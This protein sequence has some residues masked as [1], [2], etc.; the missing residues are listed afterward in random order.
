MPRKV[1]VAAAQMEIISGDYEGNLEKAL[2]MIKEAARN[3]ADFVCLPEF[4][5]TGVPIFKEEPIPGPTTD[6]LCEKA[7]ELNI[8][9]IGGTIRGK[10]D[11]EIYNSCCLINRKG[12]I[13]ANYSKIHLWIKE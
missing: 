7:R 11:G 8:N 1:K 12:E 3:N 4:F 13:L 6:F 9:V 2:K 10:R 5:S